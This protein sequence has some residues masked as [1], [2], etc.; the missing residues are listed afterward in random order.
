M[1]TKPLLHILTFESYNIALSPNIGHKLSSDVTRH[2]LGQCR[3]QI[4][5]PKACFTKYITIKC[6]YF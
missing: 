5:A 6:Y 2:I 3:P 1:L 4:T